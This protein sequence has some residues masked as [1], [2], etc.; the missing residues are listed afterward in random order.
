[1]DGIG[2]VVVD[3]EMIGKRRGKRPSTGLVNA[4][5]QD[6]PTPIDTD[7]TKWV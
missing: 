5:T 1:M 2:I 3:D 7:R 4:R 6:D